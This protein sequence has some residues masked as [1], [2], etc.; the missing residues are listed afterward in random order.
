MCSRGHR[1]IRSSVGVLSRHSLSRTAATQLPRVL[2]EQLE[3]LQEDDS[4]SANDVAK[5]MEPLIGLQN[6]FRCQNGTIIFRY[7]DKQYPLAHRGDGP[8]PQA[9]CFNGFYHFGM[10]GHLWRLARSD[11]DENVLS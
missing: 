8:L 9:T 7:S 5:A 2:T 6:V 11:P 10:F 3:K 1:R 4:F